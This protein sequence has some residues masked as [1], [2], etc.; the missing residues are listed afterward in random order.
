MT[1]EGS[2]CLSPTNPRGLA[3]GPAALGYYPGLEIPSAGPPETSTL[4][5]MESETNKTSSKGSCLFRICSGSWKWFALSQTRQ[6][7]WSLLFSAVTSE[8]SSALGLSDIFRKSSRSNE[9]V[10]IHADIWLAHHEKESSTLLCGDAACCVFCLLIA[11]MTEPRLLLWNKL[12]TDWLS[13]STFGC[14]SSAHL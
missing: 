5:S 2:A 3:R 4:E 14:R 8:D 12:T 7:L 13:Q 10:F 9:T 11:T 1:S 6:W